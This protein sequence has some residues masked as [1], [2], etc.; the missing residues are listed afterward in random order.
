M[1]AVRDDVNNT[2]AF[3]FAQAQQKDREAKSFRAKITTE[4]LK[5][6]NERAQQEAESLRAV[7]S[8][9]QRATE[10]NAPKFKGTKK[11]RG[12]QEQ[13]KSNE[14]LEF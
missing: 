10:E 12:G 8:R 11:V 5:L 9:L 1:T 6:A 4:T 2:A 14:A 7:V 13:N 3:V